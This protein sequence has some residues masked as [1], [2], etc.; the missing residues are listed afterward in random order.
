MTSPLERTVD[1]AVASL[2][3][4]SP[5]FLVTW[6]RVDGLDPLEGVMLVRAATAELAREYVMAE[7]Q[8]Q[9]DDAVHGFT[10][11]SDALVRVLAVE[12][13]PERQGDGLL[14]E[15]RW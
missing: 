9:L 13:V 5:L 1:P 2:M 7:E 10:E 3:L 11:L 12:T 8:A 15:V 14:A 6:E 4:V